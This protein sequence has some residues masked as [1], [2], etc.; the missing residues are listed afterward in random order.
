MA[1]GF[2]EIQRNNPKKKTGYKTIFEKVSEA[3]GGERKSYDW[4]RS[5]VAS[6]SSEYKKDPAKLLR[7]ENQ[8]RASQFADGN[9]LRRYPVE[10]HL[11][12]FEYKAKMKWLPYYDTFPLVYVMKIIDENEFVGANL[13]YMAPKKRVKVIQDIM[14]DKIDIPKNCFHKYILNHVQGYM[15]DLHK[16]EW[17]TAILLPVENF[18]KDVSGHKFPYKKE[19]VWKET[20]EKFYDKIKGHRMVMGYGSK[21]S[22]EMVK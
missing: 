14:S 2:S 7:Q 6:L 3:T 18:V 8:D 17:D 5:K 16:D 20:N 9:I 13:H 21:G 19:D 1:T 15:L 4:Y 22:K 10:G 12:F 11:Y